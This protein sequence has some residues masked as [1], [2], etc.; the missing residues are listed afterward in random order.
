MQRG[1]RGH[2]MLVQGSQGPAAPFPEIPS[3]PGIPHPLLFFPKSV[4]VGTFPLFA[5]KGF[6]ARTSF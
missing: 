4:L 1:S 5:A 3:H 6:P 2:L